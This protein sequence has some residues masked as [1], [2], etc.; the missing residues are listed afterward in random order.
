MAAITVFGKPNCVQCTQ[1]VKK[2]EREGLEAGRDFIYRDVTEDPAAFTYITDE[3][4]PAALISDW[5]A[6]LN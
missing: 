6:L 1:T 2:F 3:L 5:W 4:W